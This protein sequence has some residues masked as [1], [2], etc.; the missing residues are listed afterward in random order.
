MKLKFLWILWL[1]WACHGSKPA[2]DPGSRR[3]SLDEVTLKDGQQIA[4]RVLFEGDAYIVIGQ[5]NG[6]F[7]IKRDQIASVRRGAAAAMAYAGTAR[8][9]RLPAFASTHQALVHQPWVKD[10]RQVP[11]TVIG[12]GELRNIPYVSHRAGKIEFNVYGDPD[13]PAAIEIGIYDTS[14]DQETRE[15]LRDFLVSVL[16]DE[17]DRAALKS[18]AL[19]DDSKELNGLTFDVD[20]PTAEDSFGGWWVTIFDKTALD[21]ARASDAELA[22]L[23]TGA[24][25]ERSASEAASVDSPAWSDSDYSYSSPRSTGSGGRVYVRGYTRKN[26]TYVQ[27]HTRSAPRRRR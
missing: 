10:L 3:P 7:T 19:G 20:P 15:Q 26:G 17:E 8:S 27:P 2:E 21:S 14:P 5:R 24:G 9:E 25:V 22:A 1:L 18:L 6:S 12:V 16:P 11:A 13:H 4:G 23:T